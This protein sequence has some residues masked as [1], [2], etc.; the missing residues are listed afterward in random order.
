[1]ALGGSL[2]Q[3]NLGVQGAT[4]TSRNITARGISGEIY[5]LLEDSRG[6]PTRRNG[7]QSHQFGCQNDANLAL[8]PRFRQFLL[9]RHYNRPRED[10]HV[11]GS[12]LQ[13]RIAL[14]QEGDLFGE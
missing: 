12:I 14:H 5:Y 2:P 1:M 4:E 13:D 8:P 6:F 7:H 11:V 9:N 10:R 3:I